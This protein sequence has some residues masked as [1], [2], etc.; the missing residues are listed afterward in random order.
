MRYIAF[1]ALW[2]ACYFLPIMA[3]DWWDVHFQ[4]NQ[5]MVS[6]FL[7][8]ASLVLIRTKWGELFGYICILQILLNLGDAIFDYPPSNYDR[9]LNFLNL[10]EFVVLFVIGGIATLHRT[11]GDGGNNHTD[12]GND[13]RRVP[14]RRG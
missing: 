1:L 9:M 10:S 7:L 6:F 14:A 13:L 11:L 12:G 2:I 4:I 3:G 8:V 5:A